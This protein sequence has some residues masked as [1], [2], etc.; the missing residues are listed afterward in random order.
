MES[1]TELQKPPFDKPISFTKLFDLKTRE[2]ILE[3]IK[4]IKENA[5]NFT[6]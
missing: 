2:A 1:V 6:A 4:T 3:T 5:E